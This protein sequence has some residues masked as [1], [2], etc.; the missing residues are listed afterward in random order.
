MPHSQHKLSDFVTNSWTW[1][2]GLIADSVLELN[3]PLL[4]YSLSGVQEVACQGVV[5]LYAYNTTLQKRI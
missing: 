4:D 1:L 3:K 5:A 2:A